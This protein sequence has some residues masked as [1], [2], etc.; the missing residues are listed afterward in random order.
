MAFRINKI[1]AEI[2]GYK[3]ELNVA[4]DFMKAYFMFEPVEMEKIQELTMEDILDFFRQNEIMKNVDE[5]L[6]SKMIENKS[7]GQSVKIASGNMP[8]TGKDGYIVYNFDNKNTGKAIIDE[9][10]TIDFKELNLFINVEEGELLAE[11]VLPEEG[12]QGSNIKGEVVEAKQGRE[13]LL[14]AGKNTELSED[15]LKLYS[16]ASGRVEVDGDIINVNNVYKVEKDVDASVGNIRFNGDVVVN[17]DVKTGFLIEADGNLEVKGVI[18]GSNIR[19]QG[20]LVVKGG[21]HGNDRSEIYVKGSVIC[22]YI[23]NANVISERDITTDFIAHSRVLCGNNLL[24]VGRKGH[25]V[26]G[27]TKARYQINCNMIGSPMGTKTNIEAGNDP[28]KKVKLQAYIDEKLEIEERMAKISEIINSS[29]EF[30]KRGLLS[31][32]KKKKL[33]VYLEEFNQI[34]EKIGILEN[35]I[36]NIEREIMSSYEG[37][38]KVQNKVYPGTKVVLGRHVKYIRE[39]INHSKFMIEN[40]SIAVKGL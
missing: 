26:G 32:E 5:N 15:G 9:D 13:N 34:K 25:I 38:V 11:K 8:V 40:N 33:M 1:T 21:I 22:K 19:V 35:E 28:K 23:E 27:E 37:I 7:Y 2:K 29:R 18:E 36:K 6:L 4:G 31:E 39:E 3:L 20:D 10:G 24:V 16:N 12:I 17:G 30:I 14:K